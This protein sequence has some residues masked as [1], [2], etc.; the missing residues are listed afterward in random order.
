MSRRRLELSH[1]WGAFALRD[2][3]TGDRVDP[4]D[5]PLPDSIRD[6][7]NAWSAR[8]DTTFD[9]G[10]PGKPKVD[11]WVLQELAQEGA[12][13]WRATLSCLPTQAFDVSY[14]HDDVLYRQPDELPDRWRL[15]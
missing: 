7:L 9:V 4:A 6:R 1:E 2:V 12:K 10:D 11:D 3:D 8:W 13:L 5:L 14:R 15:A